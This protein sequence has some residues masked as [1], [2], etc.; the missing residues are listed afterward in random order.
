MG[1]INQTSMTGYFRN[2]PHHY[3]KLIFFICRECREFYWNRRRR[4]SGRQYEDCIIE[5]SSEHSSDDER[6]NERE[7][8]YNR[9]STMSENFKKEKSVSRSSSGIGTAS[10]NSRSN[11]KISS[12]DTSSRCF[13]PSLKNEIIDEISDTEKDLNDNYEE[14]DLSELPHGG[15]KRI[16][17]L[18]DS[19][20]GSLKSLK[21]ALSKKNLFKN[22]K[23]ES[24]NKAQEADNSWSP[25]TP[26]LGKYG[27]KTMGANEEDDFGS[28]T[29]ED[30]TYSLS[31][32]EEP[33]R[34][35]FEE[36]Y[37]RGSRMNKSRSKSYGNVS[38]SE[39]MYD[40]EVSK[41]S[42]RHKSGSDETRRRHNSGSDE[43]RRRHNS[44]SDE[45]RRRHNSGSQGKYLKQYK[46]DILSSSE[47]SDTETEVSKG[48][49]VYL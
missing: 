28:F 32:F 24:S 45:T 3:F 5:E 1:K 33:D 12:D 18:G 30:E 37:G 29:E 34:E 21:K 11:R 39:D 4:N 15:S 47:E 43:T 20:F 42:R 2:H 46:G 27:G 25:K 19:K 38:N 13:S 17:Q 23:R 9:A 41:R 10:H 48:Q 7:K 36:N 6:D 35:N 8:R 22:R 26:V 16:K 49:G 44:G 14:D 40:V 31:D